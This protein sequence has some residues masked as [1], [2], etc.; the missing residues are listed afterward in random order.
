ML[1]QIL[2]SLWI[3]WKSLFYGVP[4]GDPGVVASVALVAV[5]GVLAYSA[6]RVLTHS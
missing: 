4:F 2:T 1:T 3:V 6:K 5:I